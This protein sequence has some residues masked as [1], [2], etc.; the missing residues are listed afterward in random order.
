MGLANYRE[1]WLDRSF[2]NALWLAFLFTTLTTVI[3]VC[4]AVVVAL[5]L[6]QVR[7]VSRLVETLLVVPM[8]VIPVVS[9][10]VF[11]Y[12]ADPSDGIIGHGFGFFGKEAPGILDHPLW[13]FAAVLVQDVW[14]MWPFVFMVVYAGLRTLSH[15]P[16]EAAR[17]DVA[18]TLQIWR[19]ITLPML[20]PTLLVAVVLKVIESLK[21]FTE[22][23]VMTGGGP[24]ESTNILSMFIVKQAFTFFHLSYASAASAVL[25]GIGVLVAV[26]L[27][28]ANKR[29]QQ[30]ALQIELAGSAKE[31]GRPA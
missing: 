21:A 14:R 5:Y 19:Y 4:I 17:L 10:L 25:F 15:A 9:G 13:A 7:K 22:I 12:L 29:A 18:S 20:R 8:F 30:R 24:G 23:Y 27:S 28:A 31:L 16:F 11:R 2:H 26:A 3:E 6:N 1:L